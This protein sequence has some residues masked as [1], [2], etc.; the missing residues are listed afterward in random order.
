MILGHQ[1]PHVHALLGA[2]AYLHGAHF[3][4]QQFEQ[5]IGHLADSHQDAPGQTSLAS[6]AESGPDDGI[7]ALWQIGIGHH[8]Q[9]IF[10]ATQRLH[11]LSLSRRGLVN[12]L[13]YRR[14][15]DE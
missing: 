4:G 13:G 14:G 10:R 6:G 5:R 15:S 1:R 3:F 12:V 8:H 9:M 11:A 7:H 2:I